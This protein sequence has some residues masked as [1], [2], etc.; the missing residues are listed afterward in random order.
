MAKW[1]ITGWSNKR[2]HQWK[3]ENCSLFLAY[4]LYKQLQKGVS[5]KR[6]RATLRRRCEELRTSLTET[7]FKREQ[8]I[9]GNKEADLLRIRNWVK[10]PK[11]NRDKEDKANLHGRIKEL[12]KMLQDIN[13]DKKKL[14]S[15]TRSKMNWWR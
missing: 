14:E 1:S 5:R 2:P 13:N 15:A 12:N 9:R 10:P 8:A 4:K 6:T 7:H 11:R 3:G